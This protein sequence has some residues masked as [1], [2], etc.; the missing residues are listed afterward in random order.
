M[1]DRGL[2]D[3]ISLFGEKGW[4]KKIIFL[5]F[6]FW[7]GTVYALYSDYNMA[8]GSGNLSMVLFL[9]ANT[10][11][12]AKRIR[13]RYKARHTQGF[14][15]RFLVFHIWLNTSAFGVACYHCYVSL[16][17]NLWLMLALALMGWL[18]IGGFL[19]WIRFKPSKMKKGIYLLHTQQ[20]VFFIM[21]YAM[22]KGHYVI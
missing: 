2:I 13:L 8:T 3:Q 12:P 17:S 16:W 5:A 22:L 21:I 11:F 9:L 15:N 1:K 18:T 4:K 19:M 10:Y 20:V 7:L 6:F 14:F